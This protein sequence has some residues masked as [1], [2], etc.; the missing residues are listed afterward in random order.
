MRGIIKVPKVVTIGEIYRW[1]FL[2][3]KLFL[4]KLKKELLK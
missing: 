1:E 3:K 4:K 2:E